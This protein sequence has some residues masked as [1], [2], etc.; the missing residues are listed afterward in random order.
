[1]TKRERIY[2]KFGGMCAYSGTPLECDWQIEHIKPVVRN[3][4]NGDMVFPE[5]DNEDNMVPVQK[6]INHYKHS[7]SLYEFRTWLLG[8]LHERLKKLPKNPRTERGRKRKEYLLKVAGYFGIKED[9]PFSGVF[10]FE[11]ITADKPLCE[12]EKIKSSSTDD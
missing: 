6:L 8:G 3:W 9:K 2:N 5:D 11:T 1:M 4:F 7:I 10:Y 12:G